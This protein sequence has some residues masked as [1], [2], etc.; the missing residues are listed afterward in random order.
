MFTLHTLPVV[1][2][3]AFFLVQTMLKL[4]HYNVSVL[5]KGH[6]NNSFSRECSKS[7]TQPA[8]NSLKMIIHCLAFD[9]CPRESNV[10]I[11][12]EGCFLLSTLDVGTPAAVI[13]ITMRLYVLCK[14]ATDVKQI[15]VTNFIVIRVHDALP[16]ST[17]R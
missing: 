12:F 6:Y 5:Y 1:S 4:S 13:K 8:V 2:L 17:H 15:R 14:S 9:S 3:S 10:F 11:G 16:I 7:L